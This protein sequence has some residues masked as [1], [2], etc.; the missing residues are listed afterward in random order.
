MDLESSLL[1]RDNWVIYMAS[2]DYIICLYL[3]SLQTVLVECQV[4][5]V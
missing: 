2:D 4:N 1:L 5:G 3:F